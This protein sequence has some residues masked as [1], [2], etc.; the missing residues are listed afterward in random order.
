CYSN[1]LITGVLGLLG[2][3]IGVATGCH[4]FRKIHANNWTMLRW[5]KEHLEDLIRQSE[6]PVD[7]RVN[8]A[9]SVWINKAREYARDELK[10]EELEK[11]A[12]KMCCLGN[13]DVGLDIDRKLRE[14]DILIEEGQRISNEF[15]TRGY[16]QQETNFIG[17]AVED[18][19]GAIWQVVSQGG[20]GT[21]C[22]HGIADVGKTVVVA[23]INNQAVKAPELFDFVIW[24]DVSNGADLQRLQEDIARRIS[25]NFPLDSNNSTRAHKLRTALIGKNKFLLILDSMWQGYS[26]SQIEIPELTGGRKLIVTSRLRSVLDSMRGK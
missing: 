18:V 23:A 22:I 20:I 3:V 2:S 1:G 9:V 8:P 5:R 21:I 4:N 13:I 11:T 15:V 10:I 6:Q 24:V 17:R 25:I 12:S 14:L 7:G 19:K 26:P 16:I